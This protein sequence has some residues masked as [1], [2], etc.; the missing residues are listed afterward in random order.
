MAVL[1]ENATIQVP[2]L[3]AAGKWLWIDSNG[4]NGN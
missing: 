4:K 1:Y 3:Y 2:L